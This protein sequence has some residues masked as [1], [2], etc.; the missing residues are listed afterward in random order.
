MA[1]KKQTNA[2]AKSAATKSVVEKNEVCDC[3]KGACK[4]GPDCNCSTECSGKTKLLIKSGVILAS[5]ILISGA[6]LTAGLD[7]SCPRGKFFADGGKDRPMPTK[8]M[9]KRD[10]AMRDFIMK[11]PKVLIDSVEAYYKAQQAGGAGVEDCGDAAPAA[12]PAPQKAPE[13]QADPADL[14]A[15]IV[16]D[17]SN[18]VLGNPKGK[19][20][21]IEFFDYQCG[22]C[23]KTN[24][25][26]GLAVKSTNN[27]R[28]I[29]IDTPIFG[30][31]SETISRYGMAAAKQGK[32]A[33]MHEALTNA[34]GR[35]DEAA[36]KK[37]GADLGMDVKKLEE[38]ANSDEIKAK[39]AANQ[40]L[41]RQL[42]INGVPMLIVDGKI[43]PGALIG[44]KLQEA[45]K[46]ANA[47][48]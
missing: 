34:T 1:N 14:V 12:K 20:V 44:P 40:A 8:F 37:M 39:L 4:C 26:M 29:L 16:A 3:T 7:N 43:N 24:K 32:F 46:A 19:F 6:I 22:W 11:N 2:Q 45:V 35:L 36:L 38:D 27:I 25:E 13:L 10:A 47:K 9:E 30:P 42:D 28:W 33:Q 17:K 5:A 15:K 48:K 31:A 23:K 18:H 41:A 21:I